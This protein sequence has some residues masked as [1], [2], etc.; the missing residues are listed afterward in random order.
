LLQFA[1]PWCCR[2]ILAGALVALAAGQTAPAA[3]VQP[4]RA[5]KSALLQ[6]RSVAVAQGDDGA[7]VEIS[8]NGT[9]IPTITKLDGPPRLVIDLPGASAT[10]RPRIQVNKG[11]VK[12][13]RISQYQ[14]D[15]P[16]ARIVVDLAEARNYAWETVN[17]KLLVS[18]HPLEQQAEN[19][20]P[21]GQRE[22]LASYSA[23]EEPTVASGSGG[24]S[25]TVLKV[26][27][28][29]AD[30]SSISA[31]EQTTVLNLTRG[32]QVR[33]CPGTTISITN[34]QTGHDL[35]LGMSTG[36]VETH[37]QLAGSADSVLTPD[38]RILLQGPGDLHYAI[39]ADSK[40]NTCV[41]SLPGNTASAVVSELIGDGTYQLKPKEQVVFRSGQIAKNDAEVPI[42][43]G[44]PESAV[45]ILRAEATP[46]SSFQPAPSQQPASSNPAQPAEQTQIV[47]PTGP[48]AN[49]AP[50]FP[51][52]AKLSYPPPMSAKAQ[53]TQMQIDI[54]APLVFRATD[55]RPAP[56]REV[57]QLPA[58]SARAT[59]MRVVVLPPVK[60]AKA[61]T[62]SAKPAANPDQPHGFFGHI[63]HFFSRIF[64]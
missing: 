64:S 56:T 60:S 4:P 26:G 50:P 25:G 55:P 59:P 61:A 28:T 8:S 51:E 17:D 46:P 27:D 36:S 45:P 6:V 39:S 20:T 19:P 42:D 48:S 3:Q 1:S 43:C 44:C 35:M 31:G 40:G 30:G 34:A 47:L 14:Q 10:S 29:L 11:E 9:L 37:Y 5:R 33:I 62:A 49:A 22:L 57:R 52:Q 18:L 54:E 15:P 16:I 13:L 21:A 38:F 12:A 32:G 63:R 7:V 2:V 58:L 53:P 23:G 41:R 24:T